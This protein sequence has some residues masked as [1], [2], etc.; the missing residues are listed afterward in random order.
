MVST[1]SAEVKLLKDDNWKLIQQNTFTRWVNQHL[2][3][4][5]DIGG[6]QVDN[7]VNFKQSAELY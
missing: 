5:A 2:K 4:Q 1:P 3:K 6:P 7:L